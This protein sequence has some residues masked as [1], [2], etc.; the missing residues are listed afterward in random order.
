MYLLES[1]KTLVLESKE[2]IRD[3]LIEQF[4]RK[5]LTSVVKNGVRKSMDFT[6]NSQNFRYLEIIADRIHQNDIAYMNSWKAFNLI[7]S[8]GIALNNLVAM[9]GMVRLMGSK[10]SGEVNFKLE[11]PSRSVLMPKGTI[12]RTNNGIRFESFQD[13]LI[14]S[15]TVKETDDDGKEVEI[16][17]GVNVLFQCV[18]VGIIGNVGDSQITQWDTTP[19]P[20]IRD[21]FSNPSSFEGGRDVESDFDLKT[22]FFDL[23]PLKPLSFLKNLIENMSYLDSGNNKVGLVDRVHIRQNTTNTINS[24][25]IPGYTILVNILPKDKGIINNPTGALLAKYITFITALGEIYYN[26]LPIGFN[27]IVTK[28]NNPDSVNPIITKNFFY[29]IE[30]S[31]VT[32]NP[33]DGIEYGF[34]FFE[35]VVLYFYID[36]YVEAPI[37]QYLVEN[38]TDSLGR[39]KLKD[40]GK[41]IFDEIRVNISSVLALNFNNVVFTSR[42]FEEN[43]IY[44]NISNYVKNID[45]L[46]NGSLYAE[47]LT[48]QSAGGN[49]A[50]EIKFN[51]NQSV[52]LDYDSSPI[53]NINVLKEK[54]FKWNFKEV[55]KI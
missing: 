42:L 15:N 46:I 1:D 10:S 47:N 20:N 38:E 43:S 52:K 30:E 32:T 13:T 12:V 4:E 11:D 17:L 3:Q 39:Q 31:G 25:G 8:D 51:L 28:E 21:D 41:N 7:A 34:V 40:L 18:R 54:Y 55:K 2:L 19:I 27:T 5:G 45:V 37:T 35:E 23:K 53:R 33:L 24:V 36:L 29:N 50:S 14:M 16:D 22:R 48:F 6:P 26:N 9:K 49:F 44:S